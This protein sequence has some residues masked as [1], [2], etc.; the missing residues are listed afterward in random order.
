M[1]LRISLSPCLIKCKM[2]FA[3]ES[4]TYPNPIEKD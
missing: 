3:L 2:Q 4:S 1:P